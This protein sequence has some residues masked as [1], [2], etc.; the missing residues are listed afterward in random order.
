MAIGW[1]YARLI[2]MRIEVEMKQD[3]RNRSALKA[4]MDIRR[5]EASGALRFALGRSL[6]SGRTPD[7]ATTLQDTA[8]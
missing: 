7:C 3:L 2:D 4:E 8:P 5:T 6:A 1:A